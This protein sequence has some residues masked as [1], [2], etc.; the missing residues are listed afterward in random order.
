M[1]AAAG[2]I[3]SSVGLVARTSSAARAVAGSA[4]TRSRRVWRFSATMRRS[5]TRRCVRARGGDR[6]SLPQW[7]ERLFRQYVRRHQR[8]GLS[9]P[10]GRGSRCDLRHRL[11]LLLGPMADRAADRTA[12]LLVKRAR[13]QVFNDPWITWTA[14]KPSVATLADWV[15]AGKLRYEED[16]LVK[17]RKLP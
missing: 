6:Q 13:A 15:R 10:F 8:C 1:S 5:T 4:G 16:I 17:P 14:G 12:S 2:G 9:A 3:G 7:R 11:D